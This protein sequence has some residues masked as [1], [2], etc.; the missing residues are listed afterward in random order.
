MRFIHT[1]D[2]H[3]GRLFH[4][5]HLTNDQSYVLDQF[6]DL[7]VES[8]AQAVVIAGDIYDRAVPPTEAVE[9]LD[10]TLARLILKAKV[11]VIL[12]AGNHDS[13]ERINFGSQLLAK[14]GLYVVGNLT[15]E[16]LPI[17]L[18]DDYGKVEFM[19]FPYAEPALV[20]AVFSEQDVSDANAAMEYCIARSQQF[21]SAQSRKVAIAHAFIAGGMVS[22]SERTLSVG[23]SSYVESK[24]FQPFH[25]TALG[26][27][28][29]AQIAGGD[30]IRYSGSLLKYSFD[31]ANQRKGI[32]I[33]D[34]DKAGQVQV[35]TIALTP[36]YDVKVVEGDF[37]T[38][39][40]N[41][42]LYPFCNDYISVKLSNRE[43]ILDVFGQLSEIYPNLLQIERPT[44]MMDGALSG[45]KI[46]HR[47]MSETDL[48]ALFYQQVTGDAITEEESKLFA[49][50]LEELMLA[51]REV[52]L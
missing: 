16:I 30:N 23:G 14:Q 3:L 36:K 17:C 40:K 50:N 46:D 34:M 32:Q 52:K 10:D 35:E 8:K 1:S 47:K 31:E 12:I 51:Q 28:H 6:C 11:P 13:P 5:H 18:E 33:V 49:D 27:L 38:I 25:Y 42:N 24:L 26:H 48:F 41:R 39:L 29:N 9:L 45:K 22:E 2:W 7:V 4:G 19:P 21:L 37:Y 20:R 43:P 44:L 15:Q